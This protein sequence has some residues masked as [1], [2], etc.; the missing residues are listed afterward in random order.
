MEIVEMEDRK[1]TAEREKES[2]GWFEFES[3]QNRL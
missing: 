3:R 1:E 2:Q